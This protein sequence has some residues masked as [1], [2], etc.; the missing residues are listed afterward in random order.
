MGPAYPARRA[1]GTGNWDQP[2]HTTCSGR[3]LSE[4][5]TYSA[6]WSVFGVTS[7]RLHRLASSVGS[8]RTARLVPQKNLP[9]SDVSSEPEGCYAPPAQKR[10]RTGAV[11][12]ASRRAGRSEPS[13]S[14]WTA[15]VLWRFPPTCP[16]NPHRNRACWHEPYPVLITPRAGNLADRKSTRLN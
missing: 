7:L 9:D 5:P 15:P 8:G 1:S 2:S 3:P 16:N 11:Q 14:F 6:F 12:D 10:Q 4:N 13:A